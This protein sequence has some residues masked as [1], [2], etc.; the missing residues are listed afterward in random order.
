[1]K[2]KGR[3]ALL[4]GCISAMSILTLAISGYT[5]AKYAEI[6]KTG[7]SAFG[8]GGERMISI[9]FNANVWKEGKDS[10]GEIV[11]ANYYMYVWHSSDAENTR[12][13]IIP[14][15]HVTPTIGGTSMDLYVFEFDTNVLNHFLFLRWNPAIAPSPDLETGEGHGK[16]NQTQDQTYD[17]DTNYYCIDSWGTGDPAEATPTTNKIIKNGNTLSWAR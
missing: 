11:E 9:F 4:I 3:K 5:L 1:M 15:A 12:K 2:R 13:T 17:P 16:W 10:A 6:Q 7:Q 14:S 8:L